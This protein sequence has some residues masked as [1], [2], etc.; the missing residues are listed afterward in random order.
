[1]KGAIMPVLET[2]KF[3][4][5][6]SRRSGRDRSYLQGGPKNDPTCFCQNFVKS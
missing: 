6:H 4:S 1:M 3:N 2:V 5:D